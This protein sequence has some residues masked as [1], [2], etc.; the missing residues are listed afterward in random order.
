M[1]PPKRRKM[2]DMPLARRGI[3]GP[4]VIGPAPVARTAVVVGTTA[5]VAHGVRR[6]GDWR[7]DRRY[8]RWQV[9]RAEGDTPRAPATASG[10]RAAGPR[11]STTTMQGPRRPVAPG[12]DSEGRRP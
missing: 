10:T 6:R 5:V 2:P 12:H 3:G 1:R 11:T 4:G 8:R 7:D 9:P